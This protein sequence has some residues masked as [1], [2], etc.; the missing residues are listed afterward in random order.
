MSTTVAKK[1]K[2]N[3]RRVTADLRHRRIISTALDGYAV[4]RDQKKSLF[5]DWER[6]RRLAA[7]TKYTAINDLDRHL[8]QLVAGLESRG[9]KV[10]WASTGQE[11][12]E[13][14]V[15]ILQEQKA[16]T[17]VKSKAMTAEEIHL[18][19]ALKRA[20]LEVIETDLGE[21]IVQLRDE[22]PYHIVFPAMHLTRGEIRDTFQ[23]RLG[24]APS[25]NP[26]EL[27]MVARRV[28]RKKYVEADAGIT[29][30]NFAVADI[31][32][33]SLT[34]NEGNARLTGALPRTMITLLGIEKVVP[35]LEDLALFL[36]MLATVGAGQLIS[37]YNT[38]YG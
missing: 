30:A 18:N 17:V 35:R 19:D 29:G 13:I 22:P 34:E 1:F 20:G 10:H 37:G 24:D 21:F 8:E 27:T 3:V 4:K 5:K 9:T 16:R 28:L 11:A 23:K 25:D 2:K 26:E 38:L 7:A 31:G 14:I 6:A 32:M 36:P 12:C 33:I 15:R